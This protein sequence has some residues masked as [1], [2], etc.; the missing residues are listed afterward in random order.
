LISPLA[1]GGSLHVQ[2]GVIFFGPQPLAGT[3]WGAWRRHPRLIDR[4]HPD[5]ADDLEVVIH[6]GG[7]RLT[8]RRPELAWVRVTGVEGDVFVG[9][10]LNR[11][12]QLVT[13]S[14]GAKIRFVSP[15]GS[16]HPL[17]VT[18]KY[19]SERADWVIDPCNKCGLTELFDAPS[20]LIRVVFP[21]IPAGAAMTEFTSFCALC[22]GV[23]VVRCEGDPREPIREAE[24]REPISAEAPGGQPRP[25]WR[26]WK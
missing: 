9:R 19:L 15:E 2:S 17:M 11:P 1:T 5:Y 25:W 16:K 21:N 13:V 23:Q 14:E 10:L 24:P 6:D 18:S 12:K 4:F 20:D 3:E 26:F 8:D 22:G 7:P